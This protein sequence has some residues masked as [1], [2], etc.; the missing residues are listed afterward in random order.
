MSYKNVKKKKDDD[1]PD[2][3]VVNDVYDD[4]VMMMVVLPL[5]LSVKVCTSASIASQ[6]GEK[7][8]KDWP[9]G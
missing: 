8:G 3:G 7:W 6:S 1:F 5:S 2:Y 4:I 9:S